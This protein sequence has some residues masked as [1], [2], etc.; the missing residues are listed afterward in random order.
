ML[1]NGERDRRRHAAAHRHRGR[2]DRRHHAHL[3]RAAATRSRSSR[4]SERGTM[5]D[6]G[7]CVYM[8][9]IA[10]GPEAADVIDIERAGQGEPRSGRQGDGRDGRRR[11]RGDPRPRRA[12]PTSSASAGTPAPAS[13][14]SPTAT[15]PARSRLRGPTPGAD[16]LFGV[17][18]TPEGVIAACA[19]KCIG[20]AIHGQLWPRNDDERGAALD[21]GYDLDRVLTTDDLV[22]GDDVFFAATGIT[23]GEL[24]QG[25]AL[26][27]RGEHAVA[28][29]A[30]EV[31]HGPRDQRP[32]S[33]GQAPPDRVGRLHVDPMA[34]QCAAGCAQHRL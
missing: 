25:R 29:H 18:G 24:L 30:L 4:V 32:P 15:S 11:H 20:G 10:V 33:D 9:K 16:I 27:R 26:R 21:A 14:S 2:P 6:P 22:W 7:P 13:A 17:G 19:L 28:R 5:F 12:T 23:D 34:A 8:E 1:F 3:A 31:G